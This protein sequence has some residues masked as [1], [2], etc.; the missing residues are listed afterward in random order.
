MSIV[1]R[2]V[3]FTVAFQIII[4]IMTITLGIPEIA[5]S[6]VGDGSK[7]LSMLLF[8]G[9]GIAKDSNGSQLQRDNGLD[10]MDFITR[11]QGCME[12]VD[13]FWQQ[14]LKT[15]EINLKQEAVPSNSVL[16][17]RTLYPETQLHALIQDSKP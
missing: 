3:L 9:L 12:N 10:Q 17:Y 13:L 14:C 2:C 11:Q 7:G 15:I 8:D 5:S 1:K 4:I 16:I 6:P